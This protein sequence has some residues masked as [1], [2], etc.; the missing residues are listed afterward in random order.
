MGFIKQANKQT[1]KEELDFILESLQYN[2]PK[3]K[4]QL[5][6]EAEKK[7]KEPSPKLKKE[8]EVNLQNAV[9]KLGKP[10]G[11]DVDGKGGEEIDPKKLLAFV[12]KAGKQASAQMDEGVFSDGMDLLKV[13]G[14]IIGKKLVG[15]ETPK[16]QFQDLLTATV[17]SNLLKAK[18]N[19]K[20]AKKIRNAVDKII[21]HVKDNYNTYAIA[22]VSAAVVALMGEVITGG[23]VSQAVGDVGETLMNGLQSII[24]TFKNPS[25]LTNVFGDA[26]MDAGSSDLGDLLEKVN[27][28]DYEKISDT[29]RDLTSV[30]EG[31][32]PKWIEAT[33]DGGVESVKAAVRGGELSREEGRKVIDV[34]DQFYGQAVAIANSGG[35]DDLAQQARDMVSNF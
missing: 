14:K 4:Q 29:I 28:Y 17:E 3:T 15:K 16:D 11:V 21:T 6:N 18:V 10:K 12:A 20:T 30:G 5:L 33:L 23:G 27:A 31:E 24:D 2:P 34:L 13:A 25:E 22:L 8:L 1:K 26:L 32:N 35:G 7:N 19:H 9:K